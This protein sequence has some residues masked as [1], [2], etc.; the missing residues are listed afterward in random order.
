DTN[1]D[2]DK[3]KLDENDLLVFRASAAGDSLEPGAGP[4]GRTASMEIALRDPLNGGRGWVYL[5]AFDEEQPDVPYDGA[6]F[7]PVTNRVTARAYTLGFNPKNPI[8][9]DYFSIPKSVGGT[10]ENLCDRLKIR[11]KSTLLFGKV[12]IVRTED[13]FKS[14]LVAYRNG[15]VRSL[16]QMKSSVKLVAFL[17]SPTTVFDNIFYSDA[18]E[19]PVEIKIPFNPN[20]F[21]T[22]VETYGGLDFKGDQPN[23]YFLSSNNP[24]LV[25][26]D[27]KM[28][29]SEQKMDKGRCDWMLITGPTGTYVT[30]MVYGESLKELGKDLLYVDDAERSDPPE[31]VLGQTPIVGFVMRGWDPVRRGTHHVTTYTYRL[32]KRYTPGREKEVLQI[33]DNPLEISLA[34]GGRTGLGGGQ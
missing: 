1:E 29:E 5:F 26:I 11:V 4:A 23:T 9:W 16:V 3:G 6:H 24:T 33:L 32:E 30:R 18:M 25:P 28:S 17:R 31:E 13:D 8:S 7:D 20:I 15:P 2:S 19:F 12:A 27:G 34:P 14:K 10:E 22:D 21:F